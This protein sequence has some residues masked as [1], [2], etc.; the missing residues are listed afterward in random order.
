MPYEVTFN[1]TNMPTGYLAS[2][3][4]DGG[5]S[6]IVREFISSE[7]SDLFIS[8]LEG[9]PSQIVSMLPLNANISPGM[10]HHMLAVVRRDKTATVYI[11]EIDLISTMLL[12][13]RQ[14]VQV[15]DPI[16]E[17]DILDIEKLSLEN[18]QIPN[19]TGIIFV[20]SSGWRKGFFYDLSPLSGSDKTR[21]YDLEVVL[22]HYYA[23]LSFQHL[24]KVTEEEW[25]TL[26][27]QQWFPFASLKTKTRKQILHYVKNQSGVDDLL[28]SIALEVNE[29]ANSMLERWKNNQFIAPSFK[30]IEQAMNR[31]LA[32]DYISATSIL[33]PQIEG[34][35]RRV[36]YASNP[37]K[38]APAKKLA[39][40]VVQSR[41][42]NYHEYSLLLPIRFSKYLQDVYFAGFDPNQPTP[43]S[44]NS[45]AH[46]VADPQDYSLKAST[47][48][49]LTLDQIFYFLPIQE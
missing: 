30:L 10:I 41:H 37:P 35:M 14:N 43:V 31:Y 24:F 20:F 4:E 46:G 11:N 18:I 25:A 21:N 39:A 17:D 27:D 40:H 34:I 47:I 48:G 8:R 16:S 49:L 42:E 26:F 28:D 3:N 9:F 29:A 15:G 13:G 19:D 44:R 12:S 36:Y 1:D 45:I 22:G 7:D 6:V 5:A 32:E 2:V 23:Y 33:Y 38:K